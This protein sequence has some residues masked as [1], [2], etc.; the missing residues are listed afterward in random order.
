MKKYLFC[1]LCLL[2][3]CGCSESKQEAIQILN[4]NGTPAQEYT[5]FKSVLTDS[6]T[7]E[8][9]EGMPNYIE[10]KDTSVAENYQNSISQSYCGNK[11]SK[12]FHKSSCSSLKKTKEENKVYLS[13]RDEFI[14][15]NFSP[16]K[17]C[18]P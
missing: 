9:K 13:S 3:I 4:A 15:K 8:N 7:G 1:L 11:N 5:T 17:S 2:L 16:C 12:I 18:N 10:G 14:T 6:Y